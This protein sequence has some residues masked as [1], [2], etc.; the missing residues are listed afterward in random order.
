MVSDNCVLDSIEVWFLF[1]ISSFLFFWI[2]FRVIVSCYLLSHLFNN[3]STLFVFF[4]LFPME[5]WIVDGNDLKCGSLST[6]RRRR[7]CWS[8]GLIQVPTWYLFWLHRDLLYGGLELHYMLKYNGLSTYFN[9]Y[10][11][12]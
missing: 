7:D 9:I 11:H 12:I 8:L 6:M 3:W 1:I 5:V 2:V 4:F 10:K